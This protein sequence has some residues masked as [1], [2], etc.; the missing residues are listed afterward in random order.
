[1]EKTYFA[2]SNPEQKEIEKYFST[3]IS[4]MTLFKRLHK[5]NS[6][7]TYEAVTRRLRHMK[8]KGWNKDSAKALSKLKV[9]Y[10]DIE[11]TALNASFGFMLSWYIKAEGKNEYDFAVITKKEIQ[12]H[13]FDKRITKELLEAFKK[14]DVLYTHYG[15]DRRFDI[16]FIRTRAVI[17]GL[18]DELPGYMEKFIMD[19]WVIARNKFKFHSNRLASI[20]DVLGIEEVKKTPLSVKQW[21]LA[22][23]GDE[24]ALGYI[25]LHN[26]RDVQVL[27]KVHKKLK[28]AE[29]IV[30][31]SI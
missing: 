9:G 8:E 27:E 11:S 2:W 15:A 21:L 25:V 3:G 22:S 12:D 1:M 17:H 13:E 7:R 20:A 31:H 26:K 28:C 16:P 10:L 30:Y 14:Y 6:Q 29:R 18:Q 24:K 23:T 5:L 4:E 19:T